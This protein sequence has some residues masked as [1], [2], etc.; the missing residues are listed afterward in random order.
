MVKGSILSGTGV[1]EERVFQSRVE[2]SITTDYKDIISSKSTS[3]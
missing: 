2:R 1:I 3:T